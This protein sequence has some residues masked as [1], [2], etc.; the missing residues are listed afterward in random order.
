MVDWPQIAAIAVTL[1]AI[2]ALFLFM[3]RMLVNAAIQE[4]LRTAINGFRT[5]LALIKQA[6]EVDVKK[7]EEL[8]GYTH[9][10]YHDVMN[11]VVDSQLEAF[12][13]GKMVGMAA[14]KE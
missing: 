11:R 14:R 5:E 10:T 4:A 7:L 6:R 12:K 8:Y 1:S 9:G 3:V 2:G 13:S